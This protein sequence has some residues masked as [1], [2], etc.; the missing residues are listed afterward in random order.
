[1]ARNQSDVAPRRPGRKAS[2]EGLPEA[3]GLSD[4]E[5][6]AYLEAHPDFLFKRPELLLRLETPARV[7]GKGVVD[8]QKCMLD[9]LQGQMAAAEAARDSLVA[10]GR[11]NLAAQDRVHKAVLALVNAR[12]FPQFIESATTDLAIKLDLDVAV[13]GV[14][15]AGETFSPVRAA[16]VCQLPTRTID[17]LLGPGQRISL[18]EGIAGDA[19]IFGPAAGIVA[20]DALIRL[21]ISRMAPPALLALGSRRPED[22]QAGQRTDLLLFLAEVIESCLRGWL[23]LAE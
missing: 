11:R 14:E 12:S 1:M 19:E 9:R 18:R 10:T 13:I 4:A 6:A 5:V 15:R 20:S 23:N 16:G 17:R 22:F 2:N 7:S 21:A 8:F 3:G